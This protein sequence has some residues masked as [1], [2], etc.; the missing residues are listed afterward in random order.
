[1]SLMTEEEEAW[2][3]AQIAEE[4]QR[5][6]AEG[7]DDDDDVDETGVQKQRVGLRAGETEQV[8]DAMEM[9]MLHFLNSTGQEAEEALP[10]P[11]PEDEADLEKRMDVNQ[12]YY[13]KGEFLEFYD[14]LNEWFASPV[15]K[16]QAEDRSFYTHTEFRSFYGE[17]EGSVRW[18][19]AQPQV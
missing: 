8:D 4:E 6:G 5:I 18:H 12:Q 13:S 16:R 1:M 11:S 7:G 19:V 14:T 3:L 17:E 2:L 9:E 15:E 10:L